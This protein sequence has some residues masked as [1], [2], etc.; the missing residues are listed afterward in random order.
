MGVLGEQV[1][2]GVAAAATEGFGEGDGVYDER[3]LSF[4]GRGDPC[5]HPSIAGS[6]FAQ[7]FAVED[8]R[9]R[10]L[11]LRVCRGVRVRPCLAYLFHE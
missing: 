11:G 5:D 10:G 7:P 1:C 6:R 3:Q 8:E 4:A 9:R 2:P